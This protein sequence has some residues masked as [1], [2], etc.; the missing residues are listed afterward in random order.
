MTP[1]TAGY[2]WRGAAFSAALIL[3]SVVLSAQEVRVDG[4]TIS[5]VKE[6]APVPVT[7]E[8]SPAISA[9]PNPVTAYPVDEGYP[10]VG[11]QTLASYI[12]DAPSIDEQ[13][14]KKIRMLKPKHAIPKFIYD[15]NGTKAAITGYMMPMDT[16]ESGENATSFVI[17]RSQMSCCFG[18]IPRLN[19]WVMVNMEKGKKTR[20]TMDVPMTVYGTIE[21][22][23]KYED[24]KGWSLYRMTGEKT[25]IPNNFKMW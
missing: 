11:W 16:D 20:I 22:G 5:A 19:E 23:E 25:K 10:M 4:N 6:T 2:L 1:K 7:N 13:R 17:V 21:T 24:M 15:L 8:V 3:L 9:M 12:Y 14:M 18:A